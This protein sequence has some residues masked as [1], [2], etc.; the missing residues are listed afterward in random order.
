[1][2]L[3]ICNCGINKILADGCIYV[4]ILTLMT[5]PLLVLRE[6]WSQLKRQDIE[7]C[8]ERFH[9]WRVCYNCKQHIV[10]PTLCAQLNHLQIKPNIC[11]G[12][13]STL[14]KRVWQHVGTFPLDC[15]PLREKRE[16]MRR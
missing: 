7:A 6:A 11:L 8:F 16:K 5:V 15:K 1:M 13:L 9:L 4:V 10:N 2:R 3:L 12:D 14:S